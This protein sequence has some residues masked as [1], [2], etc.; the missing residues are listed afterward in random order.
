MIDI[1]NERLISLQAACKLEAFLNSKTRKPAH[2]SKIYRLTT[3]G[4]RDAN[5]NHLRL[6][7][8]R[9]PGG[10]RTSLEAVE[11]FIAKLTDPDG[12]DFAPQHRTPG[13]RQRDH[14]RADKSLTAAG[15]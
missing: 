11:R 13:K 1:L 2:F 7:V 3:I 9:T 14:D 6:E 15:W 10:L 5:G 12:E 4:A 8:V